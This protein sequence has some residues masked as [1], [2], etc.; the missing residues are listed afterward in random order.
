[1]GI[2]TWDSMDNYAATAD[3]SAYYESVDASV[4]FHATN[5]RF[6]GSCVECPDDDLYANK[7]IAASATVTIGVAV[8][9]TFSDWPD[10]KVFILDGGGGEHLY[11]LTA[12][13]GQIESYVGGTLRATVPNLGDNRWHWVDFQLFVDDAA[14]FCIV[15]IDGVE[16]VNITG[17]DTRNAG[18]ANVDRVRLGAVAGGASRIHRWDDLIIADDAGA[19][20]LRLGVKSGAAVDTTDN[21]LGTTYAVAEHMMELNP[22]DGGA[23]SI[24][25]IDALQAHI[26]VV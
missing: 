12:A 7:T 24:A 2:L 15:E 21:A 18:N 13:S 4:A 20:S 8:E 3:L 5:G 14:G 19:R 23:W 11:F 10:D 1:M 6:G 16:Y 9:W 22:D 17:A 26:E 25:N